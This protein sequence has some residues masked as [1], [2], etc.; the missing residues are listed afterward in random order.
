M[1][2]LK[3]QKPELGF[4]LPAAGH[5]VGSDNFVIPRFARHRT[6]AE[7]LINYYYD[8]DVMAQVE[9]WVNYISPVVGSREVL[10]KSDPDV[11]NNELIFPTATTLDR[12][13]TFRGFTA[14]EDKTLNAAFTK[15]IAS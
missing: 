6:N 3:A 14:K 9:D 15:L 10:L 7:K 8:P 5:I 11:A 12:A 4:T 1:V 13:H 2:Q